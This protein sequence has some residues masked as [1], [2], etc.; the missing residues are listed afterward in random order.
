MEADAS[1]DFDRPSGVHWNSIL[2]KGCSKVIDF[3]SV[4]CIHTHT[5][6]SC[7]TWGVVQLPFRPSRL[8]KKFQDALAEASANAEETI[9]GIR[10]IRVFNAER[11]S[12]ASYA[13]EIRNSLE[14]GAKLASMGVRVLVVIIETKSKQ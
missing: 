2:R 9:S 1:D 11:F 8:R 12:I 13:K 14:I 6:A 10:T 5:Q 3:E 4:L 7:N